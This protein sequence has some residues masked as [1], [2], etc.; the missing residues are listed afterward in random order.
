MAAIVEIC[1]GYCAWGE[2]ERELGPCLV[3]FP[4]WGDFGAVRLYLELN[5]GAK[6]L[7]RFILHV[8]HPQ[9]FVRSGL[10]KLG[11]EARKNYG[12]AQDLALT[13]AR[14]LIGDGI[15]SAVD[16]FQ[17]RLPLKQGNR[18][19]RRHDDLYNKHH[20]LALTAFKVAF[21]EQYQKRADREE[22][23]RNASVLLQDLKKAFQ[24]MITFEREEISQS[25]L[26]RELDIRIFDIHTLTDK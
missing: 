21:P 7:R 26:V 17:I 24:P 18:L 11:V 12:E 3:P 22:R 15:S 19:S 14:R 13:V 1:W 5:E 8:R 16:Y 6:S 23:L 20:Q 2:L 4:L 9:F 25:A 10:G